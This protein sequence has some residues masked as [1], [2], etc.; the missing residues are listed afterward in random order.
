MQENDTQAAIEAGKLLSR[1]PIEI[2]GTPAIVI[3][4]EES[5]ETFDKLR[6]SP[7]RVIQNTKHTTAKSFI[8]YYNEFASENS[9][10]FIDKEGPTFNAVIDYHGEEPGWKDHTASFNLKKTPEFQNWTANNK[11]PMD[12]EQFALFIE[13]NLEEITTPSGAEMLEIASSIQAT[14]ETKFSSAKRLDNG[15]VQL[16]FN[17]QI[18]GTAGKTG[19]LKIPETFKIGLH[20]FEGSEPYEIQARF[21]YRISNGNLALWY[22]LIRPHKT[23][24]ACTADTEAF[25]NEKKTA[26]TTYHGTL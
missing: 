1:K 6:N 17:E 23:I 8:N 26:G 20:L 10:I 15:Q 18:D 22:E 13:E 24:D 25:I 14:T 11:K 2:N 4:N 3:S 21:R 5:L 7:L 19:Q 9:V 16:T 12:Q